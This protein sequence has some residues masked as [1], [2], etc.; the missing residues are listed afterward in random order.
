[1]GTPQDALTRIAC[2]VE[3]RYGLSPAVLEQRLCGY[4]GRSSAHD[5][6]QLADQLRIAHED[7][8]LWQALIEGLLVHETYFYRHMDQL[9]VVTQEVLPLL[10]RQ[11]PGGISAWCAGCA[12]GEEAYTLAFMMR[13]AGLSARVIGTDLSARSIAS[14]R[15]GSF[16]QTPG[17]NSFRAMPAVAWSKFSA[18]PG[19]PAVWSVAADIRAS[20]EFMVHNLVLPLPDAR[21]MN[22]ISCRNT[23]IYFSAEGQRR[24]EENIVASSGPGT[25]LLLGPA[26]RLRYTNVFEPL[27]YSHPQILHWPEH[28]AR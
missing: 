17:L 6:A 1:M 13:D 8:P 11:N 10:R 3:A 12:T 2:L 26:E 19:R 18:I 27:S 14:A 20:V 21:R 15:L 16:G 9:D 22:L 4:L 5:Q 28:K 7:H 23:L 24:V 25:I